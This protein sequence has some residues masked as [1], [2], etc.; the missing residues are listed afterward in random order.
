MFPSASLHADVACFLHSHVL[1]AEKCERVE[2]ENSGTE[3]QVL[4]Q[5]EADHAREAEIAEPAMNLGN[6]VQA[7]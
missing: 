5:E 4:V 6:I 1:P 2:H 7:A 3:Q